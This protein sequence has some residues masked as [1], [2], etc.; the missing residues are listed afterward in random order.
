MNMLLRAT[1]EIAAVTIASL[2]L[3]ESLE[4]PKDDCLTDADAQTVEQQGD[5][6][7]ISRNEDSHV[8]QNVCLN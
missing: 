1:L 3:L 4:I 8:I 5:A 7:D 2:W 6:K